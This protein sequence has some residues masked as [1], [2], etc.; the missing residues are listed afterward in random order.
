MHTIV[1][2]E[3]DRI[4]AAANRLKH[5]VDFA[6]AV[7]VLTDDFALTVED[8]EEEERRFVTIGSSATGKTLVVVYTW[9]GPKI[10]IISARN[11][12]PRERETYEAS[13]KRRHERRIRFPPRRTRGDR[14][15]ARE[16]PDHDSPG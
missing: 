1:E 12:T 15:P 16:D 7:T 8:E 10:R 5:G 9:R 4:K 13:E 6:E 11:A 2:Y 14:D 3:W